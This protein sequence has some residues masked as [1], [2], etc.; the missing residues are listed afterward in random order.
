MENQEQNKKEISSKVLTEYDSVYF[1]GL[2]YKY[3]ILIISF[4]VVSIIASVVISLLLPN[5]YAASTS[6]I[7]P[8]QSSSLLQGAIGNISSALKDFGLTKMGG[9]GS[10]GEQYSFLVIL[11]SRTV[12]DS[13][14]KLFD[15]PKRYEIEKYIM[16]NTRKEFESNIEITFE[17]EGNYTITIW[18]K[19][20]DTA[21]A[22]VKA[23]ID[24]ANGV[25]KDI[26]N[27]EARTNREHLE[28]R[29]QQ[30]DS[31]FAV[32]ADSL[33]EYS[34]KYLIFSPEDQAKAISSSFS[35]LKSEKIKQEILLEVLANKYGAA[36]SY[37]KMQ[38]NIVDELE[39]KLQGIVRSSGFA[40]NFSLDE[41]AK[42]AIEY[43][44][45]YAELE[46]FMKVKA[47]LLPMLEE[48]RLDEIRN[49]Q[50]LFVLDEAIA[51]EKKDLPKRSLI[52]AGSA[53]GSLAL[54]I[55]II[56][57]FENF[58]A[59]KRRYNDRYSV[60]NSSGARQNK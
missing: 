49:Q 58:R 33:Q 47:L 13:I 20:P 32:I 45:M 54:I 21:A 15:L 6:L 46:T 51:P 31:V 36:D 43:L 22:M 35:D 18:D 55:F 10:S 26:F 27:R 28:R 4:V 48:A 59:V 53:I 39:K 16:T 14:I 3:K 25:G 37:T 56:I 24:I 8:K 9:A 41:S 42:V 1:T 17:S 38:Q 34:R 7:P 29:M 2:L 44:R 5:W 57:L 19:N 30:T 52:V 11:E 60:K 12:K 50:T 40:G 23:Y